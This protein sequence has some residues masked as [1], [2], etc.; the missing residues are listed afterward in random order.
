[1]A[2]FFEIFENTTNILNFISLFLKVYKNYPEKV[3]PKLLLFT[4]NL[5]IPW[6]N[7]FDI[8]ET[9]REKE[10]SSFL[11]NVSQN[12]LSVFPTINLS[13]F[14]NCENIQ[15]IYQEFLNFCL[16]ICTRVIKNNSVFYPLIQSITDTKLIETAIFS[17]ISKKWLEKVNYLINKITVLVY[18]DE[19]T[20]IQPSEQTWKELVKIPFKFDVV[21]PT[22]LSSVMSMLSFTNTF[23]DEFRLKFTNLAFSENSVALDYLQ[24]PAKSHTVF[25]RNLMNSLHEELRK[26]LSLMSGNY[27]QRVLNI[28]YVANSIVKNNEEIAKND[29]NGDI[30]IMFFCFLMTD[31]I[32][33]NNKFKELSL[34]IFEFI[35]AI[36]SQLDLTKKY[37][38][39]LLLTDVM[40]YNLRNLTNDV[41]LSNAVKSYSYLTENFQFYKETKHAS[42]FSTYMAAREDIFYILR[43]LKRTALEL[44]KL[45][46][47]VTFLEKTFSNILHNNFDLCSDYFFDILQSTIIDNLSVNIISQITKEEILNQNP[48]VEDDKIVSNF[49]TFDFNDILLELNE[50]P[51]YHSAAVDYAWFYGKN[52][53]LL[54]FVV[55][56][57][58]ERVKNL[59]FTAYL[60]RCGAD[61]DYKKIISAYEKGSAIDF[62]DKLRLNEEFEYFFKD[63]EKI[64]DKLA[65]FQTFFILSFFATP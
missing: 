19:K 22:V 44:T 55:K 52:R 51:E 13:H 17:S 6:K 36:S 24:S 33:T 16:V 29:S 7:Y 8:F 34:S 37:N 5:F 64:E 9:M 57:G 39:I 3:G 65:L 54:D 30:S 59:F 11:Y 50:L 27:V 62:A 61:I 20:V 41:V 1:M 58:N 32:S 21:L 2:L 47:D 49:V 60:Q 23:I 28:A 56:N 48:K 4:R 38:I 31:S 18:N 10:I 15:I 25:A 14:P 35:N 42:V 45:K 46:Q 40:A 53:Q 12:F 26:I 43:I 63:Y